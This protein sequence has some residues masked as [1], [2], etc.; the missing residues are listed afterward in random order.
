MTNRP[1]PRH[2]PECGHGFVPW[3]AWLLTVLTPI[4]GLNWE[5]VALGLAVIV[6]V[7]GSRGYRVTATPDPD[8]EPPVDRGAA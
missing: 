2:C 1:G 7:V 4:V 5:T 3:N 8:V 6:I